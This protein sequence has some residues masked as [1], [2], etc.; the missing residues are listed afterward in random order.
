MIQLIYIESPSP[1]QLAVDFLVCGKSASSTCSVS[2]TF[3][4]S[5]MYTSVGHVVSLEKNTSEKLVVVLM[6]FYYGKAIDL[7]KTLPLWFQ[8]MYHTVR[9]VS[10]INVLIN[11][12]NSNLL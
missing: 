12:T 7:T 8:Y 2:W 11:T 4:R 1:V 5:T 9:T 6:N 10:S 3:H